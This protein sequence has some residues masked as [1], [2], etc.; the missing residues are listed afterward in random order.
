MSLSESVYVPYL[1][2]LIVQTCKSA[3]EIMG[4]YFLCMLY[5]Y[6][7]YIYMHQLKENISHLASRFGEHNVCMRDQV[8]I[9]SS[10]TRVS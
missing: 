7:L 1:N 5:I 10:Q 3:L 9:L 2:T 6:M 4:L 8:E